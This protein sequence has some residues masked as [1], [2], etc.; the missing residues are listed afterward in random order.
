VAFV[1]DDDAEGV[2]AVVLGKKAGEPFIVVQPQGLVGGD[3]DAGVGG[4]IAAIF[5][6]TMRALSP[7]AALSLV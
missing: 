7:K 2:F 5:G 1:D 3:V 6:L 4:G